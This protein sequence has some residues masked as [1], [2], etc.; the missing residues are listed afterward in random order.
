MSTP[1]DHDTEDV[2]D[3]TEVKKPVEDSAKPVQKTTDYEAA[4]KG[5]QRNYDRLQKRLDELQAKYDGLVEEHEALKISNKNDANSSQ[6]L[7]TE[8]VTKD[9]EIERLKKELQR[10]E[11]KS[12]RSKLVLSEFP[13]LAQFEGEGLL[14]DADDDDALRELLTK[15]KSTLEQQVGKNVTDKVKGAGPGTGPKKDAGELNEDQI[16][17]RLTSLA[18]TTDPTLKLEYDNLL[19]KWHALREQ[20]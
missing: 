7:K 8:I 16:Y 17:D 13:D 12:N 9:S 18:G 11:K 2:A 20:T 4:Y 5:L 6:N 3:T 14:P 10:A 15:F 19:Q 1:E